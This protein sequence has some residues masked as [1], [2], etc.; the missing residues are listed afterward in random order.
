MAHIEATF[1]LFHGARFVA[2]TQRK[3]LP[4]PL[5]QGLYLDGIQPLLN[6]DAL[7]GKR[8]AEHWL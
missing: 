2:K 4:A 7:A 3:L 1:Q 6:L 8:R 5:L